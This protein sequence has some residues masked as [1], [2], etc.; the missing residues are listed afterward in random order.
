MTETILLAVTSFLAGWVVRDAME[1]VLRAIG[2]RKTTPVPEVASESVAAPPSPEKPAI[3]ELPWANHPVWGSLPEEAF[4]LDTKSGQV[5]I[6]DEWSSL[7]DAVHIG[8][9]ADECGR[10]VADLKETLEK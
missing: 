1:R 5:Y 3:V 6:T 2:G 8:Q 7:S 10:S 9:F 4:T